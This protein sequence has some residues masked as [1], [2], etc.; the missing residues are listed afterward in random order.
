MTLLIDQLIYTSFPEVGLSTL[1]SIHVSPEIQEAFIQQV[2]YQY[3]DSYKP[4]RSGYRA[5]YL[6]VPNM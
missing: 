1:A 5:A 2:V 6:V 4:P 3:W